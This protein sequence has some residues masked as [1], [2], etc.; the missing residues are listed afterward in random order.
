MLRGK[1]SVLSL[2]SVNVYKVGPGLV[3]RN[4]NSVSKDFLFISCIL[5][6][7][8]AF[9]IVMMDKINTFQHE[10]QESGEMIDLGQFCDHT[11]MH[12]MVSYKY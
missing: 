5:M 12:N 2:I 11:S 9:L 3:A 10:K 4:K 7:G 6:T 1:A 8:Y